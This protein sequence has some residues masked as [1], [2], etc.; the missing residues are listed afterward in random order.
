[1]NEGLS[2]FFTLEIQGI[3]SLQTNYLERSVLLNQ[4]TKNVSNTHKQKS[5][6]MMG[7]FVY[8]TITSG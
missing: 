2:D 5:P 6:S 1:M 3:A 8:R 7:F 4:I